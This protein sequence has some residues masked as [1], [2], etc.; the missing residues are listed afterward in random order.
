MLIDIYIYIYRLF[1]RYYFTCCR[2]LY[3]K[4]MGEYRPSLYQGE[5]IVLSGGQTFLAYAIMTLAYT[6]ALGTLILE[7]CFKKCS[8]ADQSNDLMFRKGRKVR[9]SNWQ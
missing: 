6:V 5:T 2:Y 8:R 3:S 1:I 9:L 4:W 7:I